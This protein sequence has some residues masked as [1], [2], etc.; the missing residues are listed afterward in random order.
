M[1]ADKGFR[2]TLPIVI[3][4]GRATV[5]AAAFVMLAVIISPLPYMAGF[6]RELYLPVM[7][8]ADIYFLYILWKSRDAG[9][10]AKHMKIA[11]FIALLAFIA[12]LL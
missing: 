9:F 8:V 3:G 4:K 6:F 5:S 10:C 12:G 11:Q 1:G 2:N 7:V